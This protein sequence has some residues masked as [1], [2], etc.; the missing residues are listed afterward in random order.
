MM[1]LLIYDQYKGCKSKTAKNLLPFQA[2]QWLFQ[3]LTSLNK[4]THHKSQDC[5]DLQEPMVDLWLSN[6]SK[7]RIEK[8]DQRVYI[9]MLLK[10]MEMFNSC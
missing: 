4:F 2:F 1:E 3:L 10:E 8:N 5:E 6:Q 9:L 7:A